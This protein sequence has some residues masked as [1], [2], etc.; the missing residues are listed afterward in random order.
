MRHSTPRSFNVEGEQGLGDECIECCHGSGREI[1]G[2]RGGGETNAAA[3]YGRIQA[4][5]AAGGRRPTTSLEPEPEQLPSVLKDGAG[6]DGH[7]RF[8]CATPNE[9]VRREP[10]LG[11]PAVRASEALGPLQRH[12]IVPTGF[13]RGELAV[14]FGCRSRVYYCPQ[15]QP[16]GATQV[17]VIPLCSQE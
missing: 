5:G 11:A 7:C 8:A 10:R 15:L 2:G 13:L 12:Q 1:E 17:K 6:G 14:E 4:D 16:I 9:L 3:V